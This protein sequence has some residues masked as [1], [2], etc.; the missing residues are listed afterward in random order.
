MPELLDVRGRGP[1]RSPSSA[2][3]VRP[4]VVFYRGR[5]ARTATP[6]CAPT[7]NNSCRPSERGI[8]LIAVSTQKPDGS[9]TIAQAN[10]LTFTVMS[11]PGN[12][13]AAGLGILTGPDERA[14]GAQRALGLDLAEHSADRK[15]VLPM[16]T[17]VI[18]DTEGLIRWIETPNDATRSEP[19]TILAALSALAAVVSLIKLGRALTIAMKVTN[20][21]KDY[22]LES[23]GDTRGESR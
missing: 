21:W 9:L 15:R 4:V 7:S 5:D 22:A 14:Q 10:E 1:P 8:A 18:V 20:P 2:S 13:I 19:E 23:Q 17:T 3:A 11:D 6:R 12:Q 16:P